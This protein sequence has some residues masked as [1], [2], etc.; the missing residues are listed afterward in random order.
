MIASQRQ[1]LMLLEI[2]ELE[3][4]SPGGVQLVQIATHHMLTWRSLV[5]RGYVR[6]KLSDTVSLTPA[7]RTFLTSMTT[8]ETL[9]HMRVKYP[10][11]KG[12]HDKFRARYAHR[13]KGGK[14]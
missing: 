6:L 1:L 3:R 14:R 7:G 9:E 10:D 11:V 13:R 4:H 8:T 12:R 5:D 2:Q